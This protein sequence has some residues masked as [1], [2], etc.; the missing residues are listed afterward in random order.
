MH[1]PHATCPLRILAVPPSFAKRKRSSGAA[2]VSASRR[3]EAVDEAARM[4]SWPSCA[5][6]R[7]LASVP[8]ATKGKR[9]K[10]Q[11]IG[12]G[13]PAPTG[14]GAARAAESSDDDFEMGETLSEEERARRA[15]PGTP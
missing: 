6:S 12:P 13:A 4:D 14:G 8:A 7:S 11:T 1:S 15:L 5:C 3:S 9:V 2:S 10:R